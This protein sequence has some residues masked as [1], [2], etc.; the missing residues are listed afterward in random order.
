MTT[1]LYLRIF[2]SAPGDA[3]QER[4]LAHQVIKNLMHD[5]L[6]RDRVV[7]K[8]VAS[9]KRDSHMPCRA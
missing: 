1:P 3:A 2:L 7:L 9:D 5:P 8:A 4:T 6:L